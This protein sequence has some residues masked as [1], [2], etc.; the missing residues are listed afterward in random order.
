M[1][2]IVDN[3]VNELLVLPAEPDIISDSI[4]ANSQ[5][6]D[7]RR[8]AEEYVRRRRMADRG[9]V[10]DSASTPGFSSPSHMNESKGGGG[11]SEVAKKGPA[12]AKEESNAAF[13]IVGGKKKGGKR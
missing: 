3:F 9:Q 7:G 2:D 12:P 11:W 1:N 6:L 8:F 10:P 4:Y 13:K 5:T